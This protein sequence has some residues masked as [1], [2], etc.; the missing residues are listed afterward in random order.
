M[1][2]QVEERRSFWDTPLTTWIAVDWEKIILIALIVLAITT[3]FWDLGARSY[4]H[5]ESIHTSESHDLYIGKG[6]IHN[7]IYHGP[8]LY[9]LTAATFFLLGDTDVTARVP[10]AVLGIVLVT[11]PYF[12]RRW[13]GRFGWITTSLILLISP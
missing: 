10:N 7:P 1:A 3:R 5:D 6:Y 11:L 8:L 12:F 2:V 13:L 9:H 4:N